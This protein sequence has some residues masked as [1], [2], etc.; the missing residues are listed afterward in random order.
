MRGVMYICRVA[1]SQHRT[2]HGRG[3]S[4]TLSRHNRHSHGS[5]A[6]PVRRARW[7]MGTASAACGKLTD[8]KGL[9]EG[10]RPESGGDDGSVLV[11]V[12]QSEQEGLCE[13][14]NSEE[15]KSAVPFGE[16]LC[17]CC[18][19]VQTE[20]WILLAQQSHP[21]PAALPSSRIVQTII[22]ETRCG[23]CTCTDLSICRCPS[24]RAIYRSL[25][26]FARSAAVVCSGSEAASPALSAGAPRTRPAPCR[27][28]LCSDL[29]AMATVSR[30]KMDTVGRTTRVQCAEC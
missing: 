9:H 19:F 3:R 8:S 7:R 1:G 2:S 4:V 16:R 10:G 30:V 15:L 22:Q 18:H 28:A 21:L 29:C 6:K 24:R 11:R 26:M 23:L 14:L 20:V 13:T 12:S 25:D 5:A 27:S 17:I